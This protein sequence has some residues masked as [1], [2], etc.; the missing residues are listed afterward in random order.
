MPPWRWPLWRA[1]ADRFLEMSMQPQASLAHRETESLAGKYLTFQLGKEVYGLEILKVREIIGLMDVT[2][3]PRTPAH[4]RGVINL[5]GKIIPVVDLRLKFAMPRKDDTD[6]TC[7][8]VVDLAC[9]SANCQMGLLVDSVSEVLSITADAIE[10]A[11]SFGKGVNAE[12]IRGIA[13]CASKVA[14]LLNVESV[15]NSSEIVD[16]QRVS[17]TGQ[18]A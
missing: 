7:I 1:Q 10:P 4:V 2:P 16:L 9:D 8:I 17:E 3:V 14:I 18:A 13:K 11:P 15:L 6:Q 12:F 5:R